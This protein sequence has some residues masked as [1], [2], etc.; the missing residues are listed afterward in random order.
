M[1][2]TPEVV[3]DLLG[4]QES[5]PTLVIHQGAARVVPGAELGAGAYAGS[6]VVASRDDVRDLAE[7]VDV[8]DPS[9]GDLQALAQRLDT[10]AAD[11][12]G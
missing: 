5:D 2:V 11:L 4:S 12:G 3:R 7:N 6:V 9:E 1:T 8:D 10:A